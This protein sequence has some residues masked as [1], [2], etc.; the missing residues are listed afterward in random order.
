MFPLFACTEIFFE[1]YLPFAISPPSAIVF[2]KDLDLPL[3]LDHE[4]FNF[5]FTELKSEL[6]LTPTEGVID[7]FLVW[8][9]YCV[10]TREISKGTFTTFS[11][12]VLGRSRKLFHR[13]GLGI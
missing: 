8:V 5:A 7:H 10:L 11:C 4:S 9:P 12:V 13:F 1:K 6:I 2:S 3:F